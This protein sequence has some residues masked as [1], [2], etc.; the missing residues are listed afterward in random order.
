MSPRLRSLL[1]TVLRRSR[2]AL[3]PVRV[4]G[5]LAAGAKWTLYPWTSYW[6]GTHEPAVQQCL[7]E[8]WD[9]TGKRCWDLGSHF[10]FFAVGLGRRVG[11]TGAVAAFEPNPVCYDRLALHVRRNRLPWVRTFR[12]AVSDH[13]GHELFLEY[14]GFATQSTSA[15][16]LYQNETWHAGIPTITIETCRLDDLVAAQRITLPDF[17]KLDV[18]GHGHQA[19]AGAVEA[20]RRQRPV[21]LAGLHSPDEIDGLRALLDPLGYTWRCVAPQVD[22]TETLVM[23]DVLLTPRD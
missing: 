17:I 1:D 11:P 15:H 18:E 4:R 10:G 3:W 13:A 8:L 6:R 9:W 5:G 16:L 20:I 12:V 14:D 23:R 2:L 22:P 21:I 7:C 19:L